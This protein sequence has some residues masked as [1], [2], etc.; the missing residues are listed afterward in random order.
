MKLEPWLQQV[1]VCLKLGGGGRDLP[2]RKTSMHKGK[3][4]DPRPVYLGIRK[5]FSEVEGCRGQGS[6]WMK[7]ALQREIG[8][9]SSDK[10]TTCF[11]LGTG[12][13][14]RG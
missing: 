9:H 2:A 13:G 6:E 12:L 10:H 5:S 1:G 7:T 11:M 4:S 3:G 14:P 8:I